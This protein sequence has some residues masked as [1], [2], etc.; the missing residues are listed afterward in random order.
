M[1]WG[2]NSPKL[3]FRASYIGMET[4]EKTIKASRTLSFPGIDK[5]VLKPKSLTMEEVQVVAELK[6]M[7]MSGDTLVYNTDAFKVS[8]EAVLLDLVRR[9]PG[10]YFEN[11]RLMYQGK[12]IQEVR[13]NGEQFF[14]TD[15]NIAL[16]NMPVSELEQVKIYDDRSERDKALGVDTGDRRT[17][18]D[19]KTKR[20]VKNIKFANAKA[21][22]TIPKHRYQLGGDIAGYSKHLSEYS[23]QGNMDNLP[24]GLS[25]NVNKSAKAYGKRK[26]ND[27]EVAGDI[28]YK[29][30]KQKD[31]SATRSESFMDA[32]N[33]YSE[34]ENLSTTVKKDVEGNFS[35]KG[36]LNKRTR[37]FFNGLVK[38]SRER[39]SSESN[40]TAYRSDLDESL[41]D[42]AEIG[43]SYRLNDQK[44]NTLSTS[45]SKRTRLRLNLSHELDFLH[46]K[47]ELSVAGN[48]TQTDKTQFN[49]SEI[50]YYQLS[51]SV[52]RGNDY[53]LT[54]T[55]NSGFSSKLGWNFPVGKKV[56]LGLNYE[57]EWNRYENERNLFDIG[58][59]GMDSYAL[60]QNYLDTR[61]DSLSSASTDQKGQHSFGLTAFYYGSKVHVSLSA[62]VYALHRNL[63]S[64][65]GNYAVDTTTNNIGFHT[66]LMM[67]YKTKRNG[68]IQFNYTGISRMPS[69][70][71][72]LPEVNNDNPLYIRIG[73][74]S[75]KQTYSQQFSVDYRG[76]VW[77]ATASFLNELNSITRKETYNE[78]TGGRI[79]TPEN[80][81]GNWNVNLN[82]SFRKYWGDFN[83]SVN[84]RYSH[85]N[86]VGYLSYAS[87]LDDV[88]EKRTTRSDNV[89]GDL[90]LGY[91]WDWADLRLTQRA[92]YSHNKDAYRSQ[93]TNTKDYS[94]IVEGGYRF[95][96]GLSLLSDVALTLRK[97]Y[98][99]EEANHS[100][101]IWNASI[102]YAFLKGRRA[103]L[104]FKYFDI[105]KRQKNISQTISSFGYNE[106]KYNRLYSYGLLTFVY[107]F[108]VMN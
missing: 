58:N 102:K 74:P 96:C 88:G 23:V 47:L 24:E 39:N 72:L 6:K 107:K 28:G 78:Q 75:L 66:L 8:E 105:L 106:T 68:Q 41:W 89:T 56:S 81:N 32:Y 82:G 4:Y 77:N 42:L 55:K 2:G 84:G 15:M 33:D 1:I 54:P 5:L 37:I 100:Q 65:R 108:N 19:M 21:G 27:M 22:V 71:D 35:I 10:V 49:R 104:E 93:E 61:V 92:T 86:R 101:L 11:G 103:S 13:L 18:M 95:R 7:F 31:E 59:L 26:I 43:D 46:S 36:R 94:T 85:Y 17:V 91:Q 70:S 29:Y 30:H 20:D 87:T 34:G 90:T 53:V 3:L 40:T 76:A 83:L 60:P 79:V 38:R 80:I 48:R 73:N 16:Q 25:T 9:L 99:M 57:W 52:Y 67:N 14:A 97:G 64:N 63:T 50:R 98:A 12:P 69:S 62:K 44:H 45:D 51:D